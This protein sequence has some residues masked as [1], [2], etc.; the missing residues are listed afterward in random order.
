MTRGRTHGEPLSVG[1][2]SRLSTPIQTQY[3]TDSTPIPLA[4]GAVAAGAGS[5]SVP[6]DTRNHQQQPST[7]RFQ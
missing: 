5:F 7:L 4:G 1:S 6:H 3:Q 2:V